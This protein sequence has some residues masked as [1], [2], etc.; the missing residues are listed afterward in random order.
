LRHYLE[1]QPFIIK[2]DHI[3]LKHLLEQRLTHALQHK[4]L[5][6]LL[7]L[8]YEIQYKKGVENK[9]ADALSRRPGL[10]SEAENYAVTE[11]MPSW[12]Q[13]LQDSYKQDEWAQQ[14]LQGKIALI[15]EKVQLQLHQGIIRKNGR[16]YVG[17]TR[18]WR[19]RVV[20]ILHDS[21]IGGH[22][23]ILGTYQRAKKLFYWPGMKESVI[24]IVQKCNTCQLNKGENVASPGLLQPIPVPEG[25]WAVVS[26]DFICGLPKSGGKDV[27][28]VIIDKFTKYC[29]L[30]TL[31]HPFKAIDVAHSFLETIYRLH[32]LPGKIITDRDPLFTCNFWKELMKLLKI[33][34]NFSTAY[35]PQTDGQTERLNQCIESYLRCM[36]FHKPKDW[37]KWIAMAE[38]WYNTNYHS[39]LKTTPFEALYG[40]QP[41]QLNMG[42]IPKSINQTVNEVLVEWQQTAKVLK[43]NLIKAQNRM[44][45]FADKKRSERTFQEGDWVYL[46]L[47]PYRQISIRGKSGTHKLKPKFYGPFEILE[48]IGAVAYKLNL[49][50]GSL[51]HPVFHVSQI[52]KC[53]GN[54][55]DVVVNLP[56][57]SPGGKLQIEP[58][59]IL[60]RR[61]V[62]RKNM[63]ATEILV[64]WSNLDDEEATWEDY[65]YI[66]N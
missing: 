32:G 10:C 20:H 59:T 42:T 14:V 1:G 48:K 29:H 28:L 49:P 64:K 51:I 15:S 45:R 12:L 41:P 38:W 40:Y 6:K 27:I 22:A 53:R 62:K 11:L 58:L 63:A 60:D 8:Q 44:K 21:S 9:A 61:L 54:V 30:I 19:D 16:I 18:D 50:A 4:G 35:H 47:Q 2:T 52:K 66:R 7:G 13:E 26:M 34:L 37:S 56:V 55:K 3:S 25:P 65:E 24:Q 5:C 17:T 39:S 46:K 36:V 57:Y 43:E 33:E 31:S 23:G